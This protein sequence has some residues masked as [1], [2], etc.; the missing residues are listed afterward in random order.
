MSTFLWLLSV[1]MAYDFPL[2]PFTTESPALSVLS[3]GRVTWTHVSAHS[4]LQV[5]TVPGSLAVAPSHRAMAVTP[6]RLLERSLS[7]AMTPLPKPTLQK[8]C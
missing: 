1:I 2:V 5:P 3:S 8:P 4:P 6:L 7:R